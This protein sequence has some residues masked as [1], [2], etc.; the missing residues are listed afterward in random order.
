MPIVTSA[1]CAECAMAAVG[2]SRAYVYSPRYQALHV[3]SLGDDSYSWTDLSTLP[4]RPSAR[5][6]VSFVAVKDKIYLVG[7]ILLAH[8]PDATPRSDGDRGTTQAPS[9]LVY[10]LRTF[11][12]PLFMPQWVNVSGLPGQPVALAE[13]VASPVRDE[14]WLVGGK[15]S[16]AEERTHLLYRLETDPRPLK[17]GAPCESGFTRDPAPFGPCVDI[18]ECLVTAPKHN[19]HPNATCWNTISSF[20]CLCVQGYHT[21]PEAA[22]CPD[23]PVY[24]GEGST[25][26]GQECVDIDECSAAYDP[27]RKLCNYYTY[28]ELMPPLVPFSQYVQ[29]SGAQ[30]ILVACSQPGS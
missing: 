11:D 8:S 27:E 13:S 19:C 20:V 4:R 21:R 22:A 9:D 23:D 24:V 18:D 3:L 16:A 10:V 6:S 17:A 1:S 12:D 29:V 14:I 26:P 15:F 25:R 28:K 30:D 7:G 2:P 5:K